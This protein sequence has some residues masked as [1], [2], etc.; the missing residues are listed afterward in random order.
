[1]YSGN[2]EYNG[3]VGSSIL[4][5]IALVICVVVFI[6]VIIIL[7]YREK[8]KT[9]VSSLLFTRKTTSAKESTYEDVDTQPQVITTVTDLTRNIAYDHPQ[10]APEPTCD[11]YK[12]M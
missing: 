9:K 12:T 3:A 7:K 1:M 10:T 6:V 5:A 11:I 2:S 8:L 4:F